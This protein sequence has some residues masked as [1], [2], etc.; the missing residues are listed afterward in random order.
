MLQQPE[1]RLIQYM[2]GA[3]MDVDDD[4]IAVLAKAMNH[5]QVLL[6]KLPQGRK[7]GSIIWSP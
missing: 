7:K 1:G 4:V 2:Y 3:A 5:F 6:F